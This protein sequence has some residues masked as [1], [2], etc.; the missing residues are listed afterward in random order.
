MERPDLE[1]IQ[2]QINWDELKE[3][4]LLL[5]LSVAQIDMSMK[6][7]DNSVNTLVDSFTSMSNSIKVI[8]HAANEIDGTDESANEDLHGIKETILKDSSI[9]AKRMQEAI[10]AFQFYD[11]LSQRLYHVSENLDELT[12]LVTDSGRLTDK[13]EWL[14]LQDKIKSSHSMIEESELYN[15]I[16]AG[17]G[18]EDAISL[19]RQKIE[20]QL[21]NGDVEDEDEIELF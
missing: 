3:T 18:I 9:V 15:A 21:A 1:S 12:A 16:I 6:D 13:Q 5:Y 2:H 7:G 20:E 4:I 14:G 11:K 19:V 17:A 8:E 10:I